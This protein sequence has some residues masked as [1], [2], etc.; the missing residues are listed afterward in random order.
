MILSHWYVYYN[1]NTAT[2]KQAASKASRRFDDTAQKATSSGRQQQ[3]L[4][5]H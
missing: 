1:T 3:T 4:S 5:K 2:Q